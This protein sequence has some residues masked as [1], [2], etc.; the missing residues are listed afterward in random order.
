[1]WQNNGNLQ[2][3]DV[4]HTSGTAGRGTSTFAAVF[5]DANNDG[6]PDLMT[7]CEFGRNDFWLGQGDGSFVPAKL[8]EI[9]GGFSMGLTVG[10]IDNDGDE[11]LIC[12][13]KEPFT[14]TG[15]DI[16][17]LFM[18]ED[19]VLVD[20]TSVYA[21]A[22]NVDGEQGFLTPTNDRDVKM[23]DLFD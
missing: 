4:T 22:S 20:R 17:I 21:I 13:R 1:M 11:D 12:V 10:D 8:P 18:N 7:A 3:T 5:F 16:N 14:S 15:R 9:Y 6:Y 23:A 2:F 19:G